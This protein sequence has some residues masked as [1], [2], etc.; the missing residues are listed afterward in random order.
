MLGSDTTITRKWKPTLAGALDVKA[1][2]RGEDM[3]L[4]VREISL[5]CSGGHMSIIIKGE[6]TVDKRTS[7]SPAD[8]ISATPSSTRWGKCEVNAAAMAP[9]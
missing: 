3:N 8:A 9:P 1:W 5:D 6:E 7:T 4:E 2:T